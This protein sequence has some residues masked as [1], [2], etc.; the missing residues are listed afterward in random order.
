MV[1]IA[2]I[3][4]CVSRDIFNRIFIK[5]HREYFDCCLYQHQM[6]IISLMAP[7]I[8]YEE[9]DLNQ[10]TL[11]KTN[12]EHFKSELQKS[13]IPALK[14]LQPQVILMDFYADTMYG[15][16]EVGNSYITGKMFKFRGSKAGEKL[17]VGHALFPRKHFDEFFEMWKPAFDR[18]MDFVKTELPGTRVI[19]NMART[20][21][22][23][24]N[25]ETGEI[26][27]FGKYDIDWLNY[28]WERMDAYAI[29]K[30]GLNA[31]FYSDKEYFLDADYPW[32]LGIVH[33]HKDF[34]RHCF[35][36]LVRLTDAYSV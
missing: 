21:S 6:S 36:Q 34:Y 16:Q 28:I 7:P 22:R 24:K 29:N 26:S 11:T 23:V 1:K 9:E 10:H 35:E 12:F 25:T 27:I 14:K 13:T 2:V 18:F 31:I 19:I 3:G 8:P 33:Y 30:Y 20:N 4:S 17:E 15:A 32:G 5:N